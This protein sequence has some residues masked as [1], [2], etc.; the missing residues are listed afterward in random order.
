VTA[1]LIPRQPHVR[2]VAIAAAVAVVGVFA[3]GMAH[4]LNRDG[5]GFLLASVWAAFFGLRQLAREYSILHHC[6][7]AIGEVV[8]YKRGLSDEP[9]QRHYYSS[10]RIR[11]RFATTDGMFYHGGSATYRLPTA[12]G[13]SIEIVYDRRNPVNNMPREHIWFYTKPAMPIVEADR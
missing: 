11:Y 9:L 13:T 10:N 3:W 1:V 2:E 4:V 7:T 5:F 12:P 8:D 6:G